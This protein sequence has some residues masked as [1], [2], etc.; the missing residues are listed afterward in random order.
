MERIIELIDNIKN[1]SESELNEVQN[2]FTDE[3]GF[4][5]NN[6][7]KLYEK[8]TEI[9]TKIRSEETDII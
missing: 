1:L 5:K 3:Y 9:S 7:E 6:N 2:F 4:I 8:I